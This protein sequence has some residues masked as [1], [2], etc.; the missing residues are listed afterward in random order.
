MYLKKKLMKA[1]SICSY[2]CSAIWFVA[3]A[4]AF[5]LSDYTYWLFLIFALLSLY[6]GFAVTSIREK[7]TGVILEKKQNTLYLICWILSIVALPSFILNAI[8]YFRKTEDEL[9]VIRQN[10]AQ[11][12]EPAPEREPEKKKPFYKTKCFVTM[13]VAFLL[14]FVCSFSA[15]IFETSGFSVKVSDFTLTKEMTE[16]YNEGKIHGKAYTMENDTMYSVT[17]YVPSN[18][19]EENPAATVFVVPGFTRTKAT[20]AQYCIELSR[21]GAVVFSLDP[22]GQGGTTETSTAGANGVEYLVQYVYNNTDDFK[23]CDKS[24]FGAVGHSA[25]GGNVCTLAA[26]F[27]GDSYSE[28]IIKSVYISGYIKA[29]SANKYKNLNCNAALSYAYYDEG[30]FRYQT[31][32]SALEVIMLRFINEV[33]G[34]KNDYKEV[35]LDYGYGDMSAGTYRIIHREKIN[36]CFEMYDKT[37]IANTLSFFDETLG[38]ESGTDPYSQIWF[39]KEVSNGLALAAAFTFVIALCAVLM[40]VPFF[41]TIKNGKKAKACVAEGPAAD[42]CTAE[43]AAGEA[44]AD[45][46]EIGAEKPTDAPPDAAVAAVQKPKTFAHKVVFWTTMILTAIIACLD[47]IPLANLSIEIFPTGNSSSVFTYVF[48]ARMINAILLWAVI[49]GAIGL[50]LYYGTTLVENLY[51]K[52]RAKAKGTTPV[53]D[54]AKLEPVKIHGEKW[55]G[56][57][58]NVLKMLL[59]C[60][61][62]FCS[63]YFLVQLCYWIFHQDFRFMLISAAPLNAR[64]FVTALEYIP[65]ILLFYVSNAIRVN[66]SIGREGWKEW[67]VLLVGAL[68]NSIGLAFILVINYVCFFMTGAPFYGYW[69]NGTEVWLYVNMVFSLVVMMFILPIFNRIFYKLT[70]GVWVG[71]IVCCS[72]FI[73]MT[74]SASVSYIPM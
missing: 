10:V 1:A 61:I 30:S 66:G 22:G 4:S 51:E 74:I 34:T 8:A 64:M 38:M 67:K 28:S 41:A 46:S 60:V 11:K 70:G 63:F 21:R 55:H 27:A 23:F 57:L 71:A 50:V 25:G 14:V 31:D 7:M 18:A 15:M 72:I 36:H 9:V 53:Y 24:R 69:G 19:T 59:L 52:L 16:T 68:A 73:M 13:C 47:Y 62:L 5:A 35:A 40:G 43:I 37:S 3:A 39:G 6:G 42:A 32:S 29:S 58:F 49:N 33:G 2:V 48:P 56:V 45:A 65:L 26:D 44:V 20:M 54:W 12:E 17:M